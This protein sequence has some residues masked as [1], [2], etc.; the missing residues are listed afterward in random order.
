MYRNECI[1]HIKMA[2]YSF[3]LMA[4]KTINFLKMRKKPRGKQ[5][6]ARIIVKK[7]YD[8]N[9]TLER[10]NN[11]QTRTHT[12]RERKRESDAHSNTSD[13]VFA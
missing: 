3:K 2:S 11:I 10:H 5:D 1:T 13:G 12:H 7:N 8:R 9:C 6:N 4:N